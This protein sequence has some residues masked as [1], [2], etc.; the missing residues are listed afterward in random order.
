GQ[1]AITKLRWGQ[2]A[3]S[4][5]ITGAA[6]HIKFALGENVKQSNWQSPTPRFPQTRMGVEQYFYDAFLR[7]KD[8]ERELLAW[9]NLKPKERERTMPPRR[10]LE[11]EAMVEILNGQRHI[12]CHSYV[13][14]EIDML[15]HV[16]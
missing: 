8:Y 2:T 6:G 7:A 1:S 4:M 13:Q 3:D 9:S 12:S 15:M 16:A 14:S 10:D 11:L 5:Q